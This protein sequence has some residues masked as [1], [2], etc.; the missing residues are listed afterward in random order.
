MIRRGTVA[1]V[2]TEAELRKR[3]GTIGSSDAPAICGI[4]PW[5]T[6]ADVLEAKLFEKKGPDARPCVVGH[7]VEEGIARAALLLGDLP[8]VTLVPGWTVTAKDGWRSATPD[9][10]CLKSGNETY[11]KGRPIRE[12][13]ALLVEVKLVGLGQM[14]HWDWGKKIPDYVQIQVQWQMSVLGHSKAAV[15]ALVG[16]DVKTFFLDRDDA[17]IA[18]AEK[19]CEAFWRKHLEGDKQGKSERVLYERLRSRRVHE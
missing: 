15:V 11:R 10:Y 8:G 2:L 18:E 1:S 6:G 14:K 7:A 17:A 4:S 13:E 12:E 3:R 9:F 19:T 5:K 16:S